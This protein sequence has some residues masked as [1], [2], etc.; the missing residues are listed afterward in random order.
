MAKKQRVGLSI[1]SIM[2]RQGG[3]RRRGAP[4]AQGLAELVEVIALDLPRRQ[5]LIE[6]RLRRGYGYH[7]LGSIGRADL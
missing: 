2:G 5:F 4:T 6:Q 7:D 1:N 3:N